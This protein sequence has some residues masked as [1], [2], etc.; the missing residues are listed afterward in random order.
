MRFS[1]EKDNPRQIYIEWEI[2][3]VGQYL[4]IELM[5]DVEHRCVFL[6]VKQVGIIAKHLSV[7]CSVLNASAR[8]MNSGTGH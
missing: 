4:C 8:P 6:S 5:F 1:S 3:D 7:S 2:N